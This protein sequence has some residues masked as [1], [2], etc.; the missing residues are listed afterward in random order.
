M[1]SW[2]TERLQKTTSSI[3]TAALHA[4][5]CQV[6]QSI[7]YCT[8]SSTPVCQVEQES[9]F[10]NSIFAYL[11]NIILNNGQ[12]PHQSIYYCIFSRSIPLIFKE[13]QKKLFSHSVVQEH[14][15]LKYLHQCHY[16]HFFSQQRK[17]KSNYS[18]L[19]YKPFNFFTQVK[20][21]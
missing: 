10:S 15:I 4:N 12:W 21:Y 18:G 20:V 11:K 13:L 17:L 5:F 2:Y 16:N 9:R 6:C 1:L 8:S 19:Q 3:T 14:F 7:Y